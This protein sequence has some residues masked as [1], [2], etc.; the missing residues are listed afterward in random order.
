[1]NRTQLPLEVK[2][3]IATRVAAGDWTLEEAAHATSYS[4]SS[5]RRWSARYGPNGHDGRDGEGGEEAEPA[6][7]VE[8]ESE[9]EVEPELSLPAICPELRARLDAVMEEHPH[10]GRQA[11][12]EW[13][14]RHHRLAV[15][16][17]VLAGYLAGSG[18]SRPGPSRK[19][20]QPPRRFEAPEP[21]ETV[22]MDL[23]YVP[24]PGKG[25][26]WFGLTVLDDHSR[27]CL[28]ERVL[29]EATA[30]AVIA[31]LATVV[32]RWGRPGRVLTDRGPQF[33][34]WKGRSRFTAYVE[35]EV[36]AKHVKAAARHPQTIGKAER[37]HRTL[38]KEAD[39]PEG[40]FEA[41]EEA[42]RALD[43]YVAWYNYVRPHQGLEGLTPADRFYGMARAVRRTMGS[44]GWRPERGVYLAANLMGRRLVIAGE[45]PHELRLL[46]D[47]G[48]DGREPGSGA[49]VPVVGG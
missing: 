45:G 8:M 43:R 1:M 11:L 9:V 2:R 26:Y 15:P 18:R 6:A 17:G 16:A 25:L 40:G 28:A 4:V 34:S 29:E 33:W 49:D 7:P 32:E 38:R 39:L 46:W 27:M 20:E 44:E 48:G 31:E 30:E 13:M 21:L 35:D 22:Q 37:F 12:R 47:E 3:M 19:T 10:F 36:G 42:Q 41:A 23:W 24:R 14:L 5:I